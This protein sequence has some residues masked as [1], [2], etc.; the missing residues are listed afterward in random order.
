MNNPFPDM[1]TF[2]MSKH[3][4]RPIQETIRSSSQDTSATFDEDIE[5]LVQLH[6]TP[7]DKLNIGA[8]TSNPKT[9]SS[10]ISSKDMQHI[11]ALSF[12][13]YSYS[14]DTSNRSVPRIT[15]KPRFHT[16][17]QITSVSIR[18]HEGRN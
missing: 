15:L 14:H 6:G 16:L 3:C 4:F 12:D 1:N 5:E 18:E 8:S 17:A 13:G 9:N 10:I 2:N 7:N 11:P